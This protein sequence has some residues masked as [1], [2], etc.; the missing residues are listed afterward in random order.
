MTKAVELQPFKLSFKKYLLE[1]LWIPAEQNRK[2]C[3]G[4]GSAL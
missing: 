2:T 3:T 4:K 1:Q